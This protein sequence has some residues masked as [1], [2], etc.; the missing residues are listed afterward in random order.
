MLGKPLAEYALAWTAQH[1]TDPAHRRPARAALGASPTAPAAAP[2]GPRTRPPRPRR[3]GWSPAGRARPGSS[4]GSTRTATCGRCPRGCGRPV[5]HLRL[6]R[7]HRPRRRPLRRR[8][9]DGARARASPPSSAASTA[10]GLL[11]CAAEEAPRFGAGTIGS[12]QLVG[13][14]HRGRAGPP[15]RR[16]RASAPPTLVP[17]YLQRARATLPR[18][19]PPLDRLRAHAEVHVAQRRALREL[20]VVTARGLAAAV[21]GAHRR[22]GRP[23]RRGLDGRPPRRAGGGRR[24]R[25]RGRGGGP[26]RAGR[27]RRHRRHAGRRARR[28]ERDPRRARAWPST[29]AAST[30]E[31]LDRWTR[32]SRAAVMRSRSARGVTAEL[33]LVR[34]GEPVTMDARLV[35]RGAGRRRASSASRPPRPGRAPGTTPSTSPRWLPRCSCS[36]RC[37]A[38]RAT[39]RRR[40][41]TW[42][43]SSRRRESSSR[44]SEPNWPRHRSYSRGAEMDEIVQTANDTAGTGGARR[45]TPRRGCERTV[46]SGGATRNSQRAVAHAMIRDQSTPRRLRL[47]APSTTTMSAL[48]RADAAVGAHPTATER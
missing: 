41:P 6:A 47:A 21:R 18:I 2:T 8:A 31:S 37:T 12:R 23:L 16:R 38:A 29:C 15:A 40:A 39:P 3:C 30:S 32:R 46:T 4:R 13:T 22:P 26:R 42:M 45:L 5:G 1:R 44:C 7:R 36:C 20:G 27:D 9:R 33:E 17:H 34:A 48:R 10:P 43:R 28:G 24:G 14:L 35:E 25:A 11:V 19:E